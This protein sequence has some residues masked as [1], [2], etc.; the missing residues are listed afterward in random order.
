M[1]R[2]GLSFGLVLTT[3]L[4]SS[5]CQLARQADSE[6]ARETTLEAVREAVEA[7]HSQKL[8]TFVA[9]AKCRND[10]ENLAR[11]VYP[12]PDLLDLRLTTR[13]SLA[14]KTDRRQI[15]NQQAVLEFEK[16]ST[17]I[18]EEEHARD[19]KAAL[20]VDSSASSARRSAGL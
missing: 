2:V 8:P 18:A 7:C 16:T 12:Y 13:L 3:G 6:K 1:K 14:E 9:R 4:L 20:P 10:A 19:S 11:S 17:L 5:G 15:S